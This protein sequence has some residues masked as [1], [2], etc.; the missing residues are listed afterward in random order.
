MT[1]E[2]EYEVVSKSPGTNNNN[3]ND[4]NDNNNTNSHTEAIVLS[5]YRCFC[6]SL[7]HEQVQLFRQLLVETFFQLDVNA[8][9]QEFSVHHS[10]NETIVMLKSDDEAVN[11]APKD[12]GGL[13]YS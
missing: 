3:N 11:Q 10:F 8:V 1:T 13:K 4:N 7:P 5:L 2:G 6:P 9:L 12:K